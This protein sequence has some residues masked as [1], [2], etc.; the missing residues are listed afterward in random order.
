MATQN[1]YIIADGLLANNADP[2]EYHVYFTELNE[3][4]ITE[5]ADVVT[6][7]VDYNNIKNAPNAAAGNYNDSIGGDS[8]LHPLS[9][10]AFSGKAQDLNGL[11]S[12]AT[13]GDYNDLHNKPSIEDFDLSVNYEEIEGAPGIDAGI[14]AD[15]ENREDYLHDF[16]K[17]AFTGEYEDLNHAP[18]LPENAYEKQGNILTGNINPFNKAAFGDFSDLSQS[19]Y[20][21][22]Y[23]INLS[24]INTSICETESGVYNFTDSSLGDIAR[25]LHNS[26]AG[27]FEA[28]VNN[29]KT[30]FLITQNRMIYVLL[31]ASRMNGDQY[32][33]IFTPVYR[34]NYASL[35][36]LSDTDLLSQLTLLDNNST[37]KFIVIFDWNQTKL[38]WKLVNNSDSDDFSTSPA[39]NITNQDIINWNNKGVSNFSGNYEDLNGAPSLPEDINNEGHAYET[40]NNQRQ[41]KTLKD[42][43]FTGDYNDLINI[44]STVNSLLS[45][46]LFEKEDNLADNNQLYQLGE[47]NTYITDF[48]QF[49]AIVN[50]ELTL[51]TVIQNMALN[52]LN[53]GKSIYLKNN[54]TSYFV[55]KIELI[56]TNDTIQYI[57]FIIY[58]MR[59]NFD[60]TV[61]SND[62]QNQLNNLNLV[63]V[64]KCII[65][66]YINNIIYCKIHD[67]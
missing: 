5:V 7:K 19:D 51:A 44:P 38:Y 6:N 3:D 4:G 11:A 22:N 13:T 50:S 53:N 9:K 10:V 45:L 30:V 32:H 60:I 33:F 55:N 37:E 66:D 17:V 48:D 25:N 21:T 42:I 8:Y 14:F 39:A 57:K 20:T 1:P 34:T 52:N 12:V 27:G 61:N 40:I 23:I 2:G 58:T 65:F 16:S 54:Q 67:I 64:L 43:A 35:T 26:F 36:Q 46:N 31:S 24:S 47:I 56:T 18:A 49:T 15:E 62:A 28:F 63:P 41:L 59:D 29:G